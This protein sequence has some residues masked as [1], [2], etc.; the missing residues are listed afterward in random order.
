MPRPP[1]W[2]LTARIL[3]SSADGGWRLTRWWDERAVRLG[4]AFRFWRVALSPMHVDLTLS[5]VSA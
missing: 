5:L 2:P 3:L 4:C 1:L